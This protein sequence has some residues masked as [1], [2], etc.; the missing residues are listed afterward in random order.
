[1]IYEY[2]LELL[3]SSVFI[4]NYIFNEFVLQGNRLL[5]QIEKRVCC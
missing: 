3:L 1:M 2:N 5:I 4:M